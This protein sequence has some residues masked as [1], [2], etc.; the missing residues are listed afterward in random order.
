MNLNLFGVNSP[1]LASVGEQYG[2]RETVARAARRVLRSF[3]DWGV[4][5]ESGAK[6]VYA[7]GTVLTVNDSR[8]IAWLIE[9]ALHARRPSSANLVDLLDSPNMF[10]FIIQRSTLDLSL[11]E[12]PRVAIIN[13]N[14]QDQLVT[15]KRL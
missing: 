4:L 9:A 11:L 10:P 14:M 13:H 3:L 1:K 15:L 12:S 8:L 5:R 2:E 6:G 7:A